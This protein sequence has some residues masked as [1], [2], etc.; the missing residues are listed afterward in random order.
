MIHE[1][2]CEQRRAR[3][4]ERVASDHPLHPISTMVDSALKEM[5]SRSMPCTVKRD[6]NRFRR[7]GCGARCWCSC[8]IR[9]RSERML[10]EKLEY[11]LLFRWFV[12]LSAN[13]AVWESTVFTK[14]RERLQEVA[15]ESNR[16]SK[17]RDR[18]RRRSSHG[19][20]K[21]SDSSNMGLS[22]FQTS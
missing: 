14:N 19:M 2:S 8:C 1:R 15:A 18:A 22:L 5:S 6:A 9:L 11:N 21:V 13:E 10:M 17:G 4:I 16:F 3:L 12:G 20:S 7:S